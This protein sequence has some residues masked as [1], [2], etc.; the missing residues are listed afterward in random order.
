RNRGRHA[1][2]G[3]D[4]CETT[5]CQR[6]D[7]NAITPALQA[8]VDQ[9]AGE[10]LWYNGSLAFTP[11]SRDCGG[12]TET[13]G[14]LWPDQAAPYLRSQ[15]DPYCIRAGTLR[16]QWTGDPA[17]ILAAL[18]RAGLRA[19]HTLERIDIV[20]RTASERAR[21]LLLAGGGE[22]VRISAGSFHTAIGAALGWNTIQ[23]ERYEVRGLSFHGSGSGH[24][25]GLC[26]RGA[27]QM[28]AE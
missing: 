13:A 26:Q 3:F 12:R 2:E 11:Y 17:A 5:H 7:L 18:T 10:L 15:P 22:S 14:D 4:F 1:A 21:T 19:P 27:D 20:Q 6:A 25:V 9:T 24:G 28:G 8:A 16:W 23:S